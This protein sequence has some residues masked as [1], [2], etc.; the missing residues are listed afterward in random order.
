M[1][2]VL[3]SMFFFFLLIQILLNKFLHIR[4]GD[5]NWFD[6][7]LRRTYLNMCESIKMYNCSVYIEITGQRKKS[8]LYPRNFI[9]VCGVD[10]SSGLQM[11]VPSQMMQW[12]RN[13]KTF[14]FLFQIKMSGCLYSYYR[15]LKFTLQMQQ[16]VN[17]SI[18]IL[19]FLFSNPSCQE[20]MC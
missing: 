18:K 5:Y 14:N 13:L 3:G 8:G 2:G 12:S 16:H 1:Q 19:F 6:T 20:K 17:S 15:C 10:P 9:L 11:G 4:N 7:Y